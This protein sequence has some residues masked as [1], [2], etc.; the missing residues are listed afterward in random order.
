MFSPA[1]LFSA[2][3]L[4]L[5]FAPSLYA[6]VTPGYAVID[7]TQNPPKIVSANINVLITE[8]N[9]VGNYVLTF[10]DPVVFFLASSMS[11]GFAFD[12]GDTLL[13]AVQ[14]SG[15][16]QKI[17]VHT[18]GISSS[19]GH[20]RTDALFSVKILSIPIFVNGFENP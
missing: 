7:G 16:R 18:S 13:T 12:A 1:R 20:S 14:D 2:L 8:G 5:S 9:G 17:N 11:K 19:E 10:D 4:L 3:F 15:N 6:Q